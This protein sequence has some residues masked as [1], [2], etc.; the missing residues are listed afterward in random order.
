MRVYHSD[1]NN[2]AV[3]RVYNTLIASVAYIDIGLLRFLISSAFVTAIA[4]VG[5]A[6]ARA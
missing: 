6:N 3:L 5:A 2:F 4:P 1:R